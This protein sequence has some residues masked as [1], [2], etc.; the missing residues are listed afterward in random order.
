MASKSVKQFKQVAR[1]LQMT[2]RQIDHATEKRVAIGGTACARVILPDNIRE[3]IVTGCQ[4]K[5]RIILAIA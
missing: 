5:A 2:D 3:L 1:E 4:A